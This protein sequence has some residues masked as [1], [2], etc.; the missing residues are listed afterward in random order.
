LAN[1]YSPENFGL[2]KRIAEIRRTIVSEFPMTQSLDKANFPA[3]NRVISG[4]S[5][6]TLVIEA[7]DKSGSLITAQ[8]ATDQGR[9]VFAVPGNILS[10][11]I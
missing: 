9:D 2:R 11:K 10:P 4:L 6:E 8:F 3:R 1:T 5:L 7:G